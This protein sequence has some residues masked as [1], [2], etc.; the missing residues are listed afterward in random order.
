VE[1]IPA[2]IPVVSEL[3]TPIKIIREHVYSGI[4]ETNNIAALATSNA[5]I[6]EHT[7][8]KKPPRR[9]A[10]TLIG[11]DQHRGYSMP[12]ELDKQPMRVLAQKLDLEEVRMMPDPARKQKQHETSALC[13]YT[14]L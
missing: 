7:N 11:G 5:G 1:T 4:S 14:G 2:L 12:E 10:V 8:A 6:E 13:V 9:A 3:K